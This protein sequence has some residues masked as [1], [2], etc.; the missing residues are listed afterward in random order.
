MN[1]LKE[2]DTA[3]LS[4]KIKLIAGVDEAGRGPLAGPV[5]AASVIFEK[6]LFHPGINDSKK[7]PEKK[8]E[9]LYDWIIKNSLCYGIGIIDQKE[10]DE[11]NILQA[12]LKAMKKAVENLNMFPQ[13][14]LIDGN[15]TFHSQIPTKTIVKGDAKSF[16]IAAA[17]IVA[18]VTRDRIMKKL[19]DDFTHYG[20]E[21]NKGYGTKEHIEAIKNLGTSPHHRLTFLKNILSE[22]EQEL[23]FNG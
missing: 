19:A 22:T 2:F 7:I 16:S 5:V 4:R 23:T 14:I 1:A 9:E 8:R 15:K 3:F 18:K 6:K 17:S 20:W 13:L 11:I 10:I 12:T 21:R